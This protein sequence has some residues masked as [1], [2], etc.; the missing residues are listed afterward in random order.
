ME[1]GLV[2]PQMEG[3]MDGATPR[4]PDIAAMAGRAEEVGLDSIWLIDHLVVRTEGRG[5]P[6]KGLWECWTALAGLAAVTSTI[7]LGSL[8]AATSLRNPTLLAKMADTVDEIS[9]GR[10]IVGLGAG[11][12]PQEHQAFGYP[13]DRRVDRFEEA[14][15][16]IAALLKT[17]RAD[18]DGTFYSARDCELKPR[19]RLEG[20]PPILVGAIAHGPR[21]LRL[22]ARHADMWNAWLVF[23][24]SHPK[25][26]APLREAVDAACRDVGR[27][28]ATLTRT[29][30]VLVDLADA[31]AYGVDVPL[32]LRERR[33]VSAV[34]GTPNE[35]AATLR[36]FGEQGIDQL[37]VCLAPNTLAALSK[38]AEIVEILRAGGT[39]E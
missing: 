38:F 31:Y 5:S 2:L 26:I 6:W 17:G 10:L 39:N 12:Y 24:E 28:P 33:S 19:P 35:I 32:R 29:A 16:V 8:V 18:Y 13:W 27:D 20:G 14:L 7:R 9:G 15:T 21:M 36:E 4:W 3:A 22:A 30:T 37:Q 34:T 1:I 23:G 25:V 11:S